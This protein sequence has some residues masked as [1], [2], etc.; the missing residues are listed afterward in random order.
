MTTDKKEETMKNPKFLGQDL[1]NMKR[2]G[3]HPYPKERYGYPAKT[4]KHVVFSGICS[5]IL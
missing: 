1:S 3:V 4:I 2:S 5:Q